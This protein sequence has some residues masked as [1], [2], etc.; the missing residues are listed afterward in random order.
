MNRDSAEFKE[1]CRKIAAV[2][3]ERK[4]RI[5]AICDKWGVSELWGQDMDLREIEYFESIL[6]AKTKARDLVPGWPRGR[7]T[8][9]PWPRSMYPAWF[10]AAYMRV[11]SLDHYEGAQR[12]L[13]ENVAND[14]YHESQQRMVDEH[15]R[16]HPAP[17]RGY[18]TINGEVVGTV[19][20]VKID[21]ELLLSYFK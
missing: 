17:I 5:K 20:E 12:L 16:R 15:R 1:I 3:A 10:Y 21:R 8:L 14:L 2:N 7:S 6:C 13:Q 9:G 11:C 19:N 18:V 4:R